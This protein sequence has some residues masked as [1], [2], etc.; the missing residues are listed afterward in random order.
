MS[1]NDLLDPNAFDS[2]LI[3]LDKLLEKDLTKNS[4]PSYLKTIDNR[5][6]N[7]KENFENNFK[8]S[9]NY[10][11][12]N[13]DNSEKILEDNEIYTLKLNKTNKAAG[14]K[15]DK[16][17]NKKKNKQEALIKA[18]NKENRYDNKTNL[19]ASA[20]I[21]TD[22][23]NEIIGKVESL[24]T[25]NNHLSKDK[26]ESIFS[27]DKQ[28]NLL[29][30]KINKL[31]Y[32]F[33]KNNKVVDLKWDS[34]DQSPKAT[35]V[36]DYTID[37]TST[38]CYNWFRTDHW[39]NKD[40]P[41]LIVEFEFTCTNTTVKQFYIGLCNNNIKYQSN[42]FCCNLDNATYFL[43]SGEVVSN[44]VRDPV[45]NNLCYL[46]KSTAN[47]VLIFLNKERQVYFSVD[48]NEEIGPYN[49]KYSEEFKVVAGC[50][51]SVNDTSLTLVKACYF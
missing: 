44:K 25:I 3:D 8:N 27:F 35:L 48:D 7:I 34:N 30:N 36:N 38:S 10:I 17:D 41:N 16:N 32:L 21:I 31:G 6:A 33:N 47:I 43:R 23:I 15:F 1:Q 50:C 49:F 14:D 42:C 12:S 26:L 28:G 29:I 9:E 24:K 51:G 40:S 39:F 5:F 46:I 22:T 45:N 13:F 18:F 11:T 4:V 37:I 20:L 19:E 2:I